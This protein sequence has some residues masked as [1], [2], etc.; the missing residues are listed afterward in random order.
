LFEGATA[1]E[2]TD[3]TLT[4]ERELFEQLRPIPLDELETDD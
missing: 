3:K 4:E 1:I 2:D